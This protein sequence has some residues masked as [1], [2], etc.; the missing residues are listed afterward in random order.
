MDVVIFI[1]ELAVFLGAIYM[2]TQTRGVG[3]GL[4]GGFGVFILVF[5]FRNQPG[6]PP[7]DVVLIIL[8]VVLAASV[9]EAAGGIN[10]MVVLAAR[11]LRSRP[12]QITLMA[13]LVTWM[14]GFGAGTGHI[15]YPLL[16]IIYDVAYQSKIRPSRPLAMSV[17]AI[18]L[19]I[20]C[21]PVSAALAAMVTLTDTPEFGVGLTGILMITIP[22]VLIGIVVGSL[23]SSR[24]GVE[25][26]DD[27]EYQRRVA[28]G[29]LQPPGATT[30][31]VAEVTV[32]PTERLSALLFIGGVVVIMVLGFFP[33]LRPRIGE[34]DASAPLGTPMVI[35]MVMFTVGTLIVL[36]CRPNIGQVPGLSVFQAGMTAAIAVFGIAWMA[37]TFVQAYEAEIVRTVGGLVTQFAWIYAIAVYILAVLIG[38]QAAITRILVPIALAAGLSPEQVIGMWPAVGGSLTLPSGA[39]AVA[40]ANF[41]LSGTTS[42]GTKLI[43]HSFII[44]MFATVISAVIAGLVIARLI[45]G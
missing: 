10:W 21:S 24:L 44:P 19:A 38:S 12:N 17:I 6:S 3:L 7:I 16:P 26:E 13:P 4:W 5:V 39:P 20:I 35:Q 27:P 45:G 25:L 18:T 37:D 31:S 29:D 15:I 8:S 2:G 9:M 22:S 43:D 33:G 32:T 28:A 40:A 36:F 42:L 30:G 41:D 1:L 11:A 34:G 23:V 14:F